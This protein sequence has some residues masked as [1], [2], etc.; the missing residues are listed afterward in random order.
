LTPEAGYD[1]PPYAAPSYEDGEENYYEP[2]TKPPVSKNK[3]IFM[4]DYSSLASSI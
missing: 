1:A 4:F 3:H 2:V